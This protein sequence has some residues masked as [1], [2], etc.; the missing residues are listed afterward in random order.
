MTQGEG[1]SATVTP[2]QPFALSYF[3]DRITQPMT[4]GA[5]KPKFAPPRLEL[6][7]R[8]VSPAAQA[9]VAYCM[10]VLILPSLTGQQKRP[11][12][13]PKIAVATEGLLGGL[14]ALRGAQ[15][16]R[17]PL[18]DSSFTEEPVSRDQFVKAMDAL[19]TAGLIDR[20][21]GSYDRTGPVARGMDTRLRL[22]K[23]GRQLVAS[24]GLSG[25]PETHFKA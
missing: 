6:G 25:D 1:V 19:E 18:S 24:Y 23:A 5:S 9:L 10:D 21:G 14:I 2:G 11:S 15:W 20:S 17:R 16:A 7:R 13:V 12:S 8:A 4:K 22:T 3:Q